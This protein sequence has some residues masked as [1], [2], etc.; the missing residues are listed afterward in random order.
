MI[1]NDKVKFALEIL[2]KYSDQSGNLP[3]ATS[4]L[5][6][7]EEF[8]IMELYQANRAETLVGQGDSQPV[9]L[10]EIDYKELAVQLH[11]SGLNAHR[12][13]DEL[14][15]S[16]GHWTKFRQEIAKELLE[17]LKISFR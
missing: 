15:K 13:Y 16:M 5:S 2:K 1:V 12:N 4:D 3:R 9:Q 11:N 7:L 17:R 6:P 8:L 10:P 14:G